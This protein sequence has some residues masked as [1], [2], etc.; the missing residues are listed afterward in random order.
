MSRRPPPRL[1]RSRAASAAAV[2]ICRRCGRSAERLPAPPYPDALGRR[3][4]ERICAECWRA[5]LARQTMVINEYRLD[6]LDAR[7]QELLTRDAVE[8]LG[9]EDEP[10][11]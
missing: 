5:Y 7:A 2:V 1:P 6:L 10:A 8:F 4:Q 9:L 3:I 11:G